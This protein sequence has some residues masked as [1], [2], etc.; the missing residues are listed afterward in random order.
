MS[1]TK[2]ILKAISDFVKLCFF[3]AIVI[4]SVIFSVNFFYSIVSGLFGSN[5]QLIHN[6]LLLVN[7]LFGLVMIIC[8][9]VF[10]AGAVRIFIYRANPNLKSSGY[11]MIKISL[12]IILVT[13][14]CYAVLSFKPSC[15]VAQ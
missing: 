6:F 15:C 14:F 10:I 8:I 7:L 4:F 9:V 11:K 13:I 1:Y 3:I 5:Q 2:I 12:F